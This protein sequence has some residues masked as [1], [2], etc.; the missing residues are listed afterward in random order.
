M[1][2]NHAKVI[3]MLF[4]HL[5]A[6]TKQILQ[7]QNRNQWY[8]VVCKDKVCKQVVKNYPVFSSCL[9]AISVFLVNR[10]SYESHITG[11]CRRVFFFAY[12]SGRTTNKCQQVIFV[13]PWNMDMFMES[14]SSFY[15]YVMLHRKIRISELLIK[16]RS[17]DLKKYFQTRQWKKER[18]WAGSTTPRGIRELLLWQRQP[19]GL[20][21]SITGN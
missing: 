18:S 21:L 20:N 16:M 4:V 7:L 12:F 9:C 10:K 14:D 3:D 13:L 11:T 8:L 5:I 1:R 15:E 2:S 19:I 6:Q 17:Q